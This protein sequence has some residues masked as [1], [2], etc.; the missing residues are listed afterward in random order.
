MSFVVESI[1]H[2]LDVFLGVT[3]RDWSTTLI[4]GS[5]FVLSALRELP[6]TEA[7]RNYLLLVLWLSLF[8]YFFNLSNQIT[9]VEEDKIN[10]PDRP[11]P[12]GNITMAGAQLRWFIAFSA[13]VGSAA[14]EPTLLPAIIC[15]VATTASMVL[16]PGGGNWFWKNTVSMTTGTWALFQASWRIVAPMTLKMETYIYAVAVW[17]GLNMQIQDLRDIKGD[18]AIGRST[19]PVVVGDRASRIIMAFVFMPMAVYVLHISGILQLAP[20]TLGILHIALVYRVLHMGGPR[21]DHKT[22][23]FFT[24]IFC[25]VIALAGNEDIALD[26]VWR[27]IDRVVGQGD[28]KVCA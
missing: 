17:T 15:W 7:I 12:S 8:L 1:A 18:R 22:Y 5:L 14:F 21:Y 13:F 2:E 23:M 11:I 25:A 28:T 3:W 19:L 16:T 27:L 4:P 20:V 26:P 9:G 10:K 6:F 24:Y